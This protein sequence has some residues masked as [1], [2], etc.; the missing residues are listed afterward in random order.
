MD[1]KKQLNVNQS[2]LQTVDNMLKHSHNKEISIPTIVYVPVDLN[3][4]IN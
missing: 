4:L 2:F 3:D 1:G